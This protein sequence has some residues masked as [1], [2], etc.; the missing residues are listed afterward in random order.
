MALKKP[1]DTRSVVPS[2]LSPNFSVPTQ[3]V[4]ENKFFHN[5][6]GDCHLESISAHTSSELQ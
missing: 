3:V 5:C 6:K 4:P 1:H 2:T